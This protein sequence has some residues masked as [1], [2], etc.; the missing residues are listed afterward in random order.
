MSET[1]NLLELIEV[2]RSYRTGA[3]DNNMIE[4]LKDVSLSVKHGE[5]LSIVGPSG[6]GKS[7]LLNIMGGLDQPDAGR[8][9]FDNQDIAGLS[10]GELSRIR[11]SRIGFIFQ[12]HHLLPQCSAI[13]NVLM[14]TLPLHSGRSTDED[15]RRAVQLLEKV[16]LS[17]RIHHRPAQLSVGECQ[18]VAV[19]RALINS[20]GI[21]LA[22]EPTG[23]LDDSSAASLADLL[24][25]LNK[26]SGLALVV[27]THSMELGG[28][29]ARRFM[30]RSGTLHD[31]D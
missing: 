29:M 24:V 28:R 15:N 7:T 8:V 31:L 6:V 2:T 19:V 27:V 11:L 10:D 4:I 13:E 5:S 21:L 1:K 18:R 20:P 9:V 16:G 23:S 30:L 3:G 22:D 26:D 12:E 25:K 17:E 14:P